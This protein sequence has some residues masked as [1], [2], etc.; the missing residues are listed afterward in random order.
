MSLKV[1]YVWKVS[2]GYV[3]CDFWNK[4]AVCYLDGL[5]PLRFLTWW[6]VSLYGPVLFPH[7]RVLW[8]PGDAH[9][10]HDRQQRRCPVLQLCGL[11]LLGRL[12]DLG[13]DHAA[14]HC[15][16]DLDGYSPRLHTWVACCPGGPRASHWHLPDR[17]NRFYSV[18]LI[19]LIHRENGIISYH[20]YVWYYGHLLSTFRFFFTFLF[21]W[22]KMLCMA[23]WVGYCKTEVQ[24]SQGL[25]SL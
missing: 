23:G 16:R 15:Q 21:I 6:R 4:C 3:S 18:V 22:L 19:F 9:P 13:A 14:L 8:E 2:H 5:W 24:E 17:E 20:T 1:K 7:S 11:R 12:Q 10:R 25:F